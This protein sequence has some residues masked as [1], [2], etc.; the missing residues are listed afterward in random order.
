MKK[1][2]LSLF[3]IAVMLLSLCACSGKT[4]QDTAQPSAAASENTSGGPVRLVYMTSWEDKV[5]YNN[6]VAEVG[7]RFAEEHPDL[8]SGVDVLP[9]SYSGYEAKFQTALSSGTYVCDIFQG[10]PQTY[11][12][13]A[14]PM[15]EAFAA[16]VDE[17][18]VDYLKD[19]GR[20]RRRS[21]RRTAGSR[22]F[23]AAVHQC[24]HV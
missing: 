11:H 20:V 6:Y 17:N 15:P 10:Q 22:Q 5:D 19:I 13:F 14:D 18:V 9:V 24:R 4:K 16:W 3:L 12:A 1:R 2:L 21:L 7:K 23:P 8:C